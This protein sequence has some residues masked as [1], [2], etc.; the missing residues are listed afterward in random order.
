MNV[1]FRSIC[2]QL[3]LFSSFLCIQGPIG[4]LNASDSPSRSMQDVESEKKVDQ[5]VL[6]IQK[7]LSIMHEVARTKW[8][9]NLPIEDKVRE[10]QILDDLV[11]K[12]NQKGLDKR[13]MVTFFQAQMDAAKEIQKRDF[14]NWRQEGLGMFPHV[15]SLKD[16]LRGYIDLLNHEIIVLLSGIS[17]NDSARFVLSRPLSCRPTDAIECDVWLMAISPFNQ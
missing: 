17:I 14:S 5:L 6:L 16:D 12:A 9:Q 3:V 1:L 7:R 15:F 2:C 11:E 13:W 4:Y 10:Q 8:N